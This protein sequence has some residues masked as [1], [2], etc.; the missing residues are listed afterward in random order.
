MFK[1]DYASVTQ[2][3][4]RPHR[5]ELELVNFTPWRDLHP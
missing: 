3:A 5:I 4:L 1:I 2:I